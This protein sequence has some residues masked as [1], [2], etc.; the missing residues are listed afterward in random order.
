MITNDYP[1][2]QLASPL[3]VYLQPVLLTIC[4]SGLLLWIAGY[5]MCSRKELA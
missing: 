2:N 1:L 5:D 3:S 4:D